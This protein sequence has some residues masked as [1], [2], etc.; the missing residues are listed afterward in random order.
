MEELLQK[1]SMYCMLARGGR[2]EEGFALALRACLC[3]CVCVLQTRAGSQERRGS[4]SRPPRLS[5]SLSLSLSLSLCVCVCVCVCV[6][7]PAALGD[8][9]VSVLFLQ[10][11]MH[12]WCRKRGRDPG[13]LRRCWGTFLS[14]THLALWGVFFFCWFRVFFSVHNP[15]GLGFR[16]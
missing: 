16:V 8:F 5:H 6:W 12:R 11:N 3:L 13:S 14:I 2:R 4:L 1:F 7:L 9:S 10:I 15:L